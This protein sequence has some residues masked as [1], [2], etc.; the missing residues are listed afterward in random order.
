MQ[1][2][3]KQTN[4]RNEKKKKKSINYINIAERKRKRNFPLQSGLAANCTCK[5][6]IG[7]NCTYRFVLTNDIGGDDCGEGGGDYGIRLK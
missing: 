2:T 3:N 7:T 5:F 6:L 1:S 4:K